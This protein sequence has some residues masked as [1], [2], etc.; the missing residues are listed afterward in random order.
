MAETYEVELGVS[1]SKV[2]SDTE[3]TVPLIDFG[4][5]DEEWDALSA[6]EQDELTT[7]WVEEFVWENT[8]SW[9]AVHRG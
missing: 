2:G 3:D 6:H 1:T 8:D 4:Y 9:V 5:T 7:S